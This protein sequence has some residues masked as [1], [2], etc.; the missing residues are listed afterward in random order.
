ML[1]Y[2][3]SFHRMK[4]MNKNKKEKMLKQILKHF[5]PIGEKENEQIISV[6]KDIYQSTLSF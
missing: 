5:Q 3:R 4:S 1:T 6:L 2:P